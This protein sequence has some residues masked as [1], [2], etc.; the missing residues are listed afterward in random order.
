[1]NQKSKIKKTGIGRIPEDW[2]EKTFGDL[3]TISRGASPR[4]IHDFM[5]STGIPWVKISDAT[6]QTSRYIDWTKEFILEKGRKNT[7]IVKPGDLIVSNSATPGIPKFMKIDAGIHDGWLLIKPK[8]K[9]NS[10]FLYY[11]FIKERMALVGIADGTVFRNL[12]TDIVR[13]HNV[14]F[15]KSLKEQQ[16]IA[17]ILSPLDAKIELN[18][19]MNKTLEAIGQAIFKKWF[20]DFEFPNEKGKPYKSNGGKMIESE[21]GMI[22]EGW[23]VDVAINLFK[24]EY[25]WHLPEWDRQI[26]KIPVFGSGGLSGFH[27]THFVEGPG[28]IMGRAGKIG[29]ESIYYSYVNFCPLETTFYV[30]TNNKKLISYLY[31]F[32]K[33][34]NMT[35]TGSSVPNLSRSSIHNAKI[36]IPSESAI[37]KFDEISKY[38]FEFLYKN[39]EETKNLEQLRDSLLPKLMSG[40]IRVP[41]N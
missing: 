37:I 9:V 30:S 14:L 24:L 2:E 26:G 35:N 13:N 7:V 10:E 16:A 15:P 22:P 28:I 41:V 39:E 31:F 5:S 4:P 11:T 36:V 38:L 8:E 21:L 20:V 25:G 33:T 32:I 1:M 18:N 19:N 23:K 40:E 6:A 12:K 34:M 27:N 17:S 29:P 3:A